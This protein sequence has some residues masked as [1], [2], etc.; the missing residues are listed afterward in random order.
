MID[1][2]ISGRLIPPVAP[3]AHWLE[4][5]SYKQLVVGS[6]PTGSKPPSQGRSMSNTENNTK[7][8]NEIRDWIISKREDRIRELAEKIEYLETLIEG[9]LSAS[10]AYSANDII[11]KDVIIKA[12]QRECRKKQK[13]IDNYAAELKRV[14]WILRLKKWE[15]MCD[16]N[17]NVKSEFL[18]RG[19]KDE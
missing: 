9:S 4:R 5:L 1:N 18:I 13:V 11:I 14:K 7:N 3:V 10:L 2:I 17:G 6:I 8:E 16:A 12:L 19:G 15:S